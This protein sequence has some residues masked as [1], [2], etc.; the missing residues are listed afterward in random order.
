MSRKHPGND[1][2]A[3][4]CQNYWCRLDL[5]LYFGEA[6]AAVNGAILPGL[7]RNLSLFAAR[8][9]D[10]SVELTLWLTCVFARITTLFASL[11]LIYKALFTVKLLLADSENK[12]L[13]AFFADQLLVLVHAFY[14][15]LD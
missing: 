1:R 14:L 5:L 11:G 10:C 15:A 8:R 13:A 4:S 2:G 7:E 3:V 6:L 9:T 12:F